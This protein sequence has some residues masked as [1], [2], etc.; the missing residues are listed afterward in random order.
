[1]PG[2]GSDDAFGAAERMRALVSSQPVLTTAGSLTITVSLG[3]AS[4]SGRPMELEQLI[5]AADQALYRAKGGGRNRV[6][7]C[8]S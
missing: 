1:L 4:T 2:C 5:T 7:R 6:E 8:T 3:V